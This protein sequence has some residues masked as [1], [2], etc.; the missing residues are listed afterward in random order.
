VALK[1]GG[2]IW[3][4]EY[5]NAFNRKSCVGYRRQCCDG[6]CAAAL[7]AAVAALA[8]AAFY[9]DPADAVPPRVQR[10]LDNDKAF[11]HALSGH[12][13][14]PALGLRRTA[15]LVQMIHN[16]RRSGLEEKPYSH[17]NSI[18]TEEPTLRCYMR[19]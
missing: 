14:P 10:M 3:L 11:K 9:F 4:L 12:E 8:A 17:I 5:L 2:R 18:I 6:L 19:L 16:I 7:A 1:A 13:A 15:R